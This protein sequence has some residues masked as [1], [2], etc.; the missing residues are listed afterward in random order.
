MTFFFK[1][2]SIKVEGYFKDVLKKNLTGLI[3]DLEDLFN[4]I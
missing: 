3:S 2:R 4:N 1:T